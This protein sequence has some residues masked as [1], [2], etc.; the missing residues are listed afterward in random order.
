MPH[1]HIKYFP[2][3]L[4]Q[5]VIETL[6]SHLNQVVGQAFNC[7]EGVISIALEPITPESWQAQGYQPEIINRSALLVKRP[8]Y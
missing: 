2:V 3:G 4:T 7:S 8:N 6:V 1:I 5:E